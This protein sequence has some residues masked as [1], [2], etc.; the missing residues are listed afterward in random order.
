MTDIDGTLIDSKKAIALAASLT[1]KE[2]QN[3]HIEPEVFFQYIGVPIK[4]VLMPYIESEDLEDSVLFFRKSLVDLGP[5]NTEV[6]PNAVEILEIFKE[7]GAAICATTNKIKPLAETVLEQQNLLRF[8]NQIFG[9]DSHSPKPSPEM[10]KSAMENFP[11]ETNIMFGD[12]PEDVLAGAQAGATT[13][14][15]SGEF[16]DLLIKESVIPDFRVTEWR[17]L[18]EIQPIKAVV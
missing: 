8:F 6:M 7:A 17:Q 4:K 15:L 14:F 13:V 10:I 12:R 5:A 16:D 1:I 2:F 3:L 11:A 9:T 18:P